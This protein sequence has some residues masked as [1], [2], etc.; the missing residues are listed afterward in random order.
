MSPFLYNFQGQNEGLQTGHNGYEGYLYV[1]QRRSNPPQ[2][3]IYIVDT[4]NLV[5]VAPNTQGGYFWDSQTESIAEGYSDDVTRDVNQITVSQDGKWLA[6]LV[7]A[8]SSTI[9]APD[10]SSFVNAA[11]DISL[12]PL[13]N[14]IPNLAGRQVYRIGGAGNGRDSSSDN[15]G[16]C[17]SSSS[18]L[19]SN[20]SSRSSSCRFR[21]SR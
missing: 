14:G 6:G 12:L 17:S 3:S 8:G 16:N 7:A 20:S 21:S 2:Y 4:T 18:N 1:N 5:T 19:S 13:T 9:F 11:N 15:S 10:G